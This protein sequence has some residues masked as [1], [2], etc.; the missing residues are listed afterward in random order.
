MPK[1]L[2]PDLVCRAFKRL[3]VREKNGKSHKERTSVLMYFLAF[4]A[5][6]KRLG[7]ETL[8]LDPAKQSGGENR[9]RL[10]IEFTNLVLLEHKTGSLKQVTEL[11]SVEANAVLPEKRMSSN[12]LTV[13]V[14]KAS[15]QQQPYEYPGRPAPLLIM[16]SG[17]TA[18][19]WGVTRHND[20]NDNISL[21]LSGAKSSTPYLDLAI[22]VCRDSDF[23]D[24]ATDLVTAL[25]DRLERRF[26]KTLANFWIAKIKK[27]RVLARHVDSPFVSHYSSFV[28]R[29]VT[30]TTKSTHHYEAMDKNELVKRVA[31][32]E[33]LL[34][35]YG[36]PI[37]DFE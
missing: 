23:E 7:I 14:K 1:H 27:E 20:W 4:D 24:K 28:S 36:I 9:K 25:G 6:C 17:A 37:P 26:T 8:D 16:G 19:K 32:L 30:D 15:R 34:K 11:G 5:T 29:C 21:F 18:Y 2:D 13:P 33:A 35:Q 10:L 22:F 3:A 12:F 31:L